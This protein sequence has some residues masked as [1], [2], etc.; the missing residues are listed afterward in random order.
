MTG[1]QT[2]ALPIYQDRLNDIITNE[3]YKRYSES[4]VKDRNRLINEKTEVEIKLENL[5]HN[6][7]SAK[8]EN[9]DCEN[10]I[11]EFLSQKEITKMSLYRL[12][13]KIEIDKDKNI[14]IHFNFSKLNI[15]SQ[16]FD[17]FIEINEIINSKRKVV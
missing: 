16:N 13:K 17:E 7:M 5:G 15:I 3:D 10:Y 6:I 4:F 1:V 11:R 2:C 8:V 9:E 12:I 14:Y